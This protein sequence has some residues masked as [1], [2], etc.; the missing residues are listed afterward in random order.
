V[1]NQVGWEV[2]Q[3]VYAA[4]RAGELGLHFG[5]TQGNNTIAFRAG[6]L[7]ETNSVPCSLGVMY[8]FLGFA[9][10]SAH[11][12]PTASVALGRVMSCA[13]D[14]DPRRASPGVTGTGTLGGGV[15]LAMFTGRR[16]TGSLD[17]MGYVERMNGVTARTDRTV[18]GVMLGLSIR[19]PWH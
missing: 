6:I 11:V 9:N 2:G 8:Q 4:S 14:N 5:V 13:S 1:E 17:L 12:K 3:A 10:T 16:I 15:R 19:G 18:K 7:D